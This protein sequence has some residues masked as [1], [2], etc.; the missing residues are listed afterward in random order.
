M[1]G[2]VTLVYGDELMKHHLSDEPPLQPIRVKLTM[3]LI[4]STGLIEQ[5]HL[6]PPRA[7]TIEELE[8][9]HSPEYVD[10]VQKLSDPAL[11]KTVPRQRVIDAGFDS[12]DNPISS[13]LHD[14]TALVAGASMVA[15]EAVES[16]AALHA[17][18]PAGGLHHA[19][20]ERA[21]GFCTYNDAAI[22]CQWLKGRGHRFPDVDVDVHQG[23]GAEERKGH[24]EG[25][26]AYRS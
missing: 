24:G 15:A 17:F 9:V 8:L 5:C 18:S 3:E 1:S 2:P 6:V 21:S 11:R 4:T 14:G 12:A 16:G 25:N 10:L 26:R 20:R 7:A 22:A 19:H 13:H 23:R